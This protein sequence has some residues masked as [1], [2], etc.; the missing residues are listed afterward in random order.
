MG[1]SVRWPS[2]KI[3]F[4]YKFLWFFVK[5]CSQSL[6]IKIMQKDCFRIFTVLNSGE[7]KK[8][9]SFHGRL[10]RA[11]CS[12]C[13]WDVSDITLMC[14]EILGIPPY[15]QRAVDQNKLV[16]MDANTVL[17]SRMIF[18]VLLERKTKI[19]AAAVFATKHIVLSRRQRCRHW[20]ED[21]LNFLLLS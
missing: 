11:L 14:R 8:S 5:F 20:C 1:W 7:L 16:N 17:G 4:I 3:H 15:M 2:T 12:V 19:S 6:T 9:P 13:I 21:D 18:L 10:F